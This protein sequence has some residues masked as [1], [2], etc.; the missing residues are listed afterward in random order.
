MLAGT[1]I[2]EAASIYKGRVFGVQADARKI[3]R[4]FSA[5]QRPS[6]MAA[7]IGLLWIDHSLTN[8]R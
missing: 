6:N 2:P 1:G 4:S 7:N 5:V 3:E 8:L